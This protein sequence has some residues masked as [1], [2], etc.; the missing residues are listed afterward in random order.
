MDAEHKVGETRNMA[1]LSPGSSEELTAPDGRTW[2]VRR[3]K[4]DP[5]TVR[6]LMRHHDV[7]VLLGESGG[8]DLRWIPDGE[9]SALSELV[10]R[11]YALPTEPAASDTVY[12]GHEFG[13]EAGQRLLYI[14]EW[15]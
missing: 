15:C 8:F 3:R 9:R 2:Q 13:D 1:R 11:N 10:L 12:M 7:P 14:E 5:R 6:S 4:L